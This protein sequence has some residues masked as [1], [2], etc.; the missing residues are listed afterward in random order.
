M[1]LNT[2]FL[3]ATGCVLLGLPI[4]AS[5]SLYEKV[6]QTESGPVY[7]YPAFNTTPSDDLT[8]WKEIAVWKGIKFAADTGGEVSKLL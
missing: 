2:L 7:G 4:L 8:N 3:R 5:A 1:T 6:V